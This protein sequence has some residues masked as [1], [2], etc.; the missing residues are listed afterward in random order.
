MSITG[1]HFNGFLRA[2]RS[3]TIRLRLAERGPEFLDRVKDLPAQFHFARG[4]EQWRIAQQYVKNQTFI[5][6]SLIHIS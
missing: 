1:E 5:G 2:P 6:L 4:W 3:G